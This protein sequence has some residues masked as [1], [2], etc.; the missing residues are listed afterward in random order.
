M[1][2]RQAADAGATKAAPA[3]LGEALAAHLRLARGKTA[4]FGPISAPNET[5]DTV[6]DASATTCQSTTRAKYLGFQHNAATETP[7]IGGGAMTDPGLTRGLH[8][9]YAG[10][11]RRAHSDAAIL[12][13][14]VCPTRPA[15]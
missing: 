9:T 15:R 12:H 4:G 14:H 3:K 2:R 6:R 13:R 7:L 5:D 11:V 10:R 1:L 8:E